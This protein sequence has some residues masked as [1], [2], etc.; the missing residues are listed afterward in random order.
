MEKTIKIISSPYNPPIETVGSIT[1]IL[2]QPFSDSVV[3]VEVDPNILEHEPNSDQP[4]YLVRQK[5]FSVHTNDTKKLTFDFRENNVQEFTAQ[6]EKY[7][8]K[9]M[10]IGIE[11]I[12][13]QGF[14]Y[15]EFLVSW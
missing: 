12:Q 1:I 7:Q 11:K 10:H 13:G 15:V 5:T 4:G 9:L 14:K 2:S 3:A 6:G 8:M